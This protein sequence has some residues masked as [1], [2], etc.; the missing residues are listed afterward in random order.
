MPINPDAALIAER[1]SLFKTLQ[2]LTPE[3][4]DTPSLCDGWRVRD[5]ATHVHLLVTIK[6]LRVL[7]GLLMNKGDFNQFMAT[8][9]P[10]QG[11]RPTS[12]ILSTF[13]S[14]AGSAEIPPTT[15][16]VELTFDCFVHHHDICLPLGREVEADPERLRWM[17]DGMVAAK[18][19]ILSGPRVDGLRLVATDIDWHYGTGPE[20]HG[21]AA[22]LILGG[23]GRTTLNH[24]LEGDGVAELERR[25]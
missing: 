13:E 24:L 8:Y 25:S 10:Q 20:I 11:K 9:V 2:T 16:K 15:K 23:C 6:P 4:W 21:P 18:K 19:P 14:M 5:V 1:T 3:E 17:A 7:G 22:A 12:E